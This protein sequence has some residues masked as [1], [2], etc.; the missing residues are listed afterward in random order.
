MGTIPPHPSGG[1][2]IDA[3]NRRGY[4]VCPC[5]YYFSDKT[6]LKQTTRVTRCT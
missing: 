2:P 4:S 6:Q 1:R 5:S 3:Y